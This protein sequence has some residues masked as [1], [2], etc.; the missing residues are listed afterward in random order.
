MK[1]KTQ[2]TALLISL[3]IILLVISGILWRFFVLP[4]AMPPAFPGAQ[5]FGADTPG[6]RFGRVIFVTNLNDTTN[7]N[8]RAYPGSLRWALEQELPDDPND[9][10]DQRRFIVFKVGGTIRLA[11]TL[12]VKHPYVTIAGQTAPGNGVTLRGDELDIATHDVIVRGLRV[13]V[14]DEGTPTCCRDAISVAVYYATGD[15]Y[16]IIIDHNSASWAIDENMSIWADPAD[17]YSI[18]DVTIQWNNISEGLYNSIHIDEGDTL[19]APHS[20][21]LIVGDR[22]S[23]ISIHHNLFSH[24]WGRNP[25]VSGVDNLEII[26]NLVYGWGD[27]AVE[28]G[29]YK[30]VTHVINNYFKADAASRPAEIFVHDPMPAGSL[31]Y[32]RGNLADDPRADAGLFEARVYN[33]VDFIFS[34]A[35]LFKTGRI[36]VDSAA[37]VYMLVLGH[38]GAVTPEQDAVDARIVHEVMT[39]SGAIIDSQNQVGGWA[40]FPPA[41][42]PPDADNDGLPDEWEVAHGLDPNDPHD[43]NNPGLLAPGGYS[44]IEAYA[45]SLI[46]KP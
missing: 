35:L 11:D 23:N 19:P 17:P 18:H 2:Q 1:P 46:P 10:Y 21:G 24:N 33:P 34:D 43:A 32:L 16:N 26:N 31:V 15:V 13:R 14:G 20:M 22:A 37:D 4:P 40:D 29:S 8:S 7:V 44:W 30:T 27:G 9:P 25:H 36:K 45:N 39:R 28:F 12:I 5:G 42:Y 41:H 38:A 3:S 6:G